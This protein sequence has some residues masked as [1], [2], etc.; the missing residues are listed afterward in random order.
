MSETLGA[1]NGVAVADRMQPNTIS[2]RIMVILH[3]LRFI[4]LF[5]FVIGFAFRISFPCCLPFRFS[6]PS[7][8]QQAKVS[9]VVRKTLRRFRRP[10]LSGGFHD[11]TNQPNVP[12]HDD[13]M[14]EINSY[15]I[16]FTLVIKID[17]R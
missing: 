8:K 16:K 12:L 1:T 14:K 2:A 6:V 17:S 11:D 4:M 9:S 13:V 10:R 3:V 5:R 15:P 7:T